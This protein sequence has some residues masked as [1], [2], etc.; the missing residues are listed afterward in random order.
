MDQLEFF[1]T[2]LTIMCS[3]VVGAVP[4]VVVGV[5]VFLVAWV[6]ALIIRFFISHVF[7]RTLLRQYQL[8]RFLSQTGYSTAL[9]LGGIIALGTMGVDIVV[10]VAGLSLT[11]FAV[12]FALKDFLSSIFSGFL[13]LFYKPFQV[14]DRITINNAVGRVID[15]NLR[16]TVLQ[17]D[18]K[19]IMIPNS[20][21]LMNIVTK[22]ETI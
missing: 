19:R 14:N 22:E 12:S 4:K 5:L 16:Y 15:I 8:L 7:A 9:I 11:G 10:L 2:F 13:I 21:V 18:N 1:K 6:L 20:T 17:E 3:K